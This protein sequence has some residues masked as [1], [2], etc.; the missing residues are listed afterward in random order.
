MDTGS[1][2]RSDGVGA[3]Q[4][5]PERDFPWLV[6]EEPGSEWLQL[7]LSIVPEKMTALYEAL[8]ATA[9]ALLGGPVTNFFFM[10]KQP[11][12]RIRFE[13]TTPETRESVRQAVERWRTD[14]LVTSILP[15]VYE[16]EYPL[17]GG[18]TSMEHVHRLFTVDSLAWLDHHASQ[19]DR[20]NRSAPV[21]LSLAMLRGLFDDLDIIGWESRD[22]W[23]RLRRVA[24]RRFTGT[25][26]SQSRFAEASRPV[27]RAWS[28]RDDLLA[29]LT[30]RDRSTLDAFREVAS[31][32]VRRWRTRY[33][34]TEQASV[35]PREAA[36]YL[37]IFHWN[38][39]R[40]STVRQTLIA[41]ALA[42]E[43]TP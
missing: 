19:A 18:P 36:A 10:H 39:A 23:D 33:F 29:A 24:N 12:M 22:V 14:G 38:R 1:I 3:H 13:I 5:D 34:N 27:R 17:F 9:R 7:G 20:S 4:A 35:G 6:R 16:P 42:T 21:N 25:Q 30:P 8:G 43:D 28:A 2:V 40:I 37:T 32:E 31:V 41:E 26:L 15:G 11:G